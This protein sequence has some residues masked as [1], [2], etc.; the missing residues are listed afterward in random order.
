MSFLSPVFHFETLL[1]FSLFLPLSSL[2]SFI[3][4]Y[5]YP[6]SLITLFLLSC[7][8]L[9]FS[10]L[11]LLH[12]SPLFTYYLLL[13]LPCLPSISY[14][15]FLLSLSSIFLLSPLPRSFL[16]FFPFPSLPLHDLSPLFLYCLLLSP[17]CLPPI[18]SFL[19]S[20]PFSLLALIF[21]PVTLPLP[22]P[23]TIPFLSPFPASGCSLTHLSHPPIF[24]FLFLTNPFSSS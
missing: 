1:F 24:S 20:F 12:L 23:L 5:I 9:P 11:P 15:L 6:F 13:S 17:L 10:Y 19:A 7:V 16:V 3:F 22:F 21:L 14:L 2:Y 8:F 18:I 4:S